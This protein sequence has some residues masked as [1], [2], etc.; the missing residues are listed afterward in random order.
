MRSE[1]KN[2]KG[3]YISGSNHIPH[4]RKQRIRETDYSYLQ[5]PL[6]KNNLL[7]HSTYPFLT[8]FPPPL[9]NLHI[10]TPSF[11]PNSFPKTLQSPSSPSLP[12]Q[13][14]LLPKP[15]VTNHPNPL[16]CLYTTPPGPHPLRS[17]PTTPNLLRLQWKE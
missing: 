4:I 8:L 16:P 11:P 2:K 13:H 14:Y 5:S 7:L 6:N 1:E 15:P 9:Y 3:K 17:Q 10:S 12:K